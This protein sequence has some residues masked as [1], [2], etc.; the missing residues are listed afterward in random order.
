[1]YGVSYVKEEI[2]R[3]QIPKPWVEPL[4]VKINTC[5]LLRFNAN[6]AVATYLAIY[7]GD[8]SVAWENSPNMYILTTKW[9]SIVMFDLNAS[10][11]ADISYMYVFKCIMY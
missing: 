6:V 10:V 2:K 3:P 1:M 11:T 4:T 9:V 7:K 8:T 5:S